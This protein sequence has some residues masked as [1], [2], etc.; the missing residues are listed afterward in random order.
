MQQNNLI[1]NWQHTNKLAI[2]FSAFRCCTSGLPNY[3]CF[4][5]KLMYLSYMTTLYKKIF[6]KCGFSSHT[7]AGNVFKVHMYRIQLRLQRFTS[8]PMSHNGSKWKSRFTGLHGIHSGL[9][10]NGFCYPTRPVAKKV[11]Y[12]TRPDP[13]TNYPPRPE[14]VGMGRVG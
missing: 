2:S 10:V 13:W 4:C 5:F 3:F 1:A 9:W 14:P 12:L 6:L 8:S 11:C 7:N